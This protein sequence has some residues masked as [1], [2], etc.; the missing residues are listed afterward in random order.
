MS[1]SKSHRKKSCNDPWECFN[2]TVGNLFIPIA[3]IWPLFQARSATGPAQS[4]IQTQSKQCW[5]RNVKK[6]FKNIQTPRKLIVADAQNVLSSF[7]S[8]VCS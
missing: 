5:Q 4:F 8:L 1:P 3:E 6:Q 7:F 2:R